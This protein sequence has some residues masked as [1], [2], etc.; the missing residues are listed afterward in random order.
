MNALWNKWRGHLHEKYV[1]NKPIQ[2]SLKNVPRGVDKKEWEWLVKENFASE[3]ARLLER[4]SIKRLFTRCVLFDMFDFDVK[5]GK[6]GNPPDLATI[7]F[8]RRIKDNNLV[9]PEA[10]EKHVRSAQLE[11]MVE[12]HQRLNYILSALRSTREDIKSLN[13]E[14][15]SLNKEKKSLNYLLLPYEIR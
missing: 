7:F 4:L 5:G 13:E 12:L 1:K 9:E 10:I 3:R 11:E 15:K 6:D 14:N 2:Q 8:E